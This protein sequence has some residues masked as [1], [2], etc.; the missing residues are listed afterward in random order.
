MSVQALGWVLDSSPTSGTD[1]LVLISIANHA[2]KAPVNGAWEAWPGVALIQKEAGLDRKRTVIDSLSRL[3]AMGA[4]ERVIN[5]APDMRIPTGKR[6]NLY[7]ILLSHGVTRDDT[8]D[9]HSGVAAALGGVS[10]GDE[11]GCREATPKPSYE[12]STSRRRARR[13]H[14]ATPSPARDFGETTSIQDTW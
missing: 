14:S 4:L 8:P 2:H 12:P 6:P 10:L 13:G 5:G 9:L 1:R 3:V 7:R 11:E